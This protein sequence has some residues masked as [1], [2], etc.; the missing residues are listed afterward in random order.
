MAMMVMSDLKQQTPYL[1]SPPLSVLRL[2]LPGLF[3]DSPQFSTL[4]E[5]G[6]G[7]NGRN[8][9][10]RTWILSMIVVVFFLQ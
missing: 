5:G 9:G 6:R 1:P 4:K 10:N 2:G 8:F 3:T 7:T